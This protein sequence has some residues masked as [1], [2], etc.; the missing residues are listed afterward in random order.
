MINERKHYLFTQRYDPKAKVGTVDMLA[1]FR[2]I[3]LFFVYPL[4]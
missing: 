2:E 1:F 4:D 3:Y